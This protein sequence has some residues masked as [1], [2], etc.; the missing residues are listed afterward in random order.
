MY[1]NLNPESLGIAGRQ[2]ELIELTM[3]YGFRGLDVDGAEL[4]K[5][6]SLLGVEEATR[7]LKSA[8]VKVGGFRLPVN[9]AADEDGFKSDLEKLGNLAGLAKQIGFKYCE[10]VL[11]PAS[12]ALP[13]HE[14]FERHRDRLAKSADL[15][16]K[17]EI[18]L[19]VGFKAAA[20]HRQGRPFQFIHQAEELLMLLKTTGSANLGLALD[21]WNWRLGGGD[22]DQMVDLKG[23]QVVSVRIA[24]VPLDVDSSTVTDSQRLLP[25]EETVV[26]HAALLKTLAERNFDGPVTLYP[27]GS[28][29]PQISRDACT[30]KCAAC[31]E[32]IWSAAGLTKSGRLATP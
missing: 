22:K 26:E 1:K 3:T 9:I 5:R 12:E 19:G 29:L 18:R 30:S 10:V 6:A 21:T 28:Q 32:K 20:S 8:N 4:I 11:D 13:Y 27:H 17:F 2:S 14:N 31:L 15:L 7:Y 25:T 23:P 16:A 24:D